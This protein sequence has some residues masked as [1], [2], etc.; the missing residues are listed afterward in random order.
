MDMKSL[1]HTKWEC[2]YHIVFISKFRRKAS[3]GELKEDIA[4]I[5]STLCKRKGV[6]IVETEICPNY[7]HM[8]GKILHS[9]RVSGFVGYLREKV[10]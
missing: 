4:N 1:A 5:L 6:E 8:L 7:V 3:Y 10:H 9:L 2:K